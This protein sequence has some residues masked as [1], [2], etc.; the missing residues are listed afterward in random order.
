MSHTACCGKC[1]PKAAIDVSAIDPMLPRP[2]RVVEIK[3]E[4]SDTFTMVLKP[5]DGGK[6]HFAPGQFNMLYV[7]GVGEIPISVSGD[8]SNI[9]TLIHTTRAVGKVSQ[10]LDN[11]KPGDSIG[12]RG[13]FGTFW[14]LAVAEGMDLVFV[15]GGIGLAPLRPAIYQAMNERHKFNNI[16]ILY[17]ARTPEDILFHEEVAQWRTR[18]DIDVQVTVDHATGNW[19]GKVGVVPKLIA[20]GGFARE[21]TVAYMCG[22]EIMMHYTIKALQE[23]GV[24]NDRIFLSMERN[25]KCGVGLCG[26]CQWGAA[27]ICRD[28]PVF[29]YDQVESVFSIKEL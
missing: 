1:H 15:A 10:A 17:G 6:S 25:M 28:G 18:F 26:H 2:F 14:P 12:I 13:P 3:R 7:F 9:T 8:P 16:S 4:L 21:T 23:R 20:S 19:K 24:T 5:E 27:F 22:P 29:R 11:L